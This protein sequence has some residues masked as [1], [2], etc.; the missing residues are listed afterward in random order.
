MTS[1]MPAEPI[2]RESPFAV[3]ELFF[4]LTDRKGIIRAGNDVFVRVSKHPE[5]GL[6]GSA[7][8]IIRHPDMPRGAFRLLWDH[9]L[10]G[11]PVAAYVKNM[12]ADGSYYWVMACVV[13]CGDGFLSVRLKPTSP[14]LA[15]A[16]V[17][18]YA[19]A[20]E[21]ER[22]LET[23]GTPRRDVAE[24][25]A[26]HLLELLAGAGFPDYASFMRTALPIEIRARAEAIAGE[27]AAPPR[28]RT[29]LAAN[30]RTAGAQLDR[31]FA[32]LDVYAAANAS[33]GASAGFIHGLADDV[34]LNALN[35]V[36]AASRL[37]DGGATLSAVAR[38]M[39]SCAS[40]MAGAVDGFSRV[41]RPVMEE[42]HDLGFR[43]SLAKAQ[44]DVAAYFA[45]ELEAAV[46]RDDAVRARRRASLAELV[47]SLER[48]IGGLLGALGGLEGHVGA[49]DDRTAGIEDTLTTLGALHVCGRIEVARASAAQGF[50]V[51][52]DELR[53]QLAEAEPHVLSLRR[54]TRRMSVA[55]FD[56][57]TLRAAMAGMTRT[58]AAAPLPG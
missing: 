27:A 9:L 45:D 6:I 17:P 33:L 29:G 55:R 49:L 40:V 44:V 36:I 3:A 58:G 20:L 57:S 24:R 1:A 25:S 56:E 22:G 52:F 54:A 53:R 14:L 12:A 13:P 38:E 7:H 42:L 51:L 4:S 18:L 31:L 46:H 5:D 41:A 39:G 8:N 47:G 19:Q 28:T 50:S 26:A 11:L 23:A 15:D 32:G 30:L 37:R 34:R 35:G 10:A 2:D 21:F 43:I 48:E 16:V